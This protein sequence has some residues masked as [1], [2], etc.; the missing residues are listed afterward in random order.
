MVYFGG[1][2]RFIDARDGKTKGFST[3]LQYLA[4]VSARATHCRTIAAEIVPT[5]QGFPLFPALLRAY[6]AIRTEQPSHVPL[7]RLFSWAHLH[8]AELSR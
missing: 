7:I 1:Q 6:V 3:R 4:A 8:Q 5:L 2:Q